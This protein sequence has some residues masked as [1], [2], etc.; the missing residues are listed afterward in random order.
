MVAYV[1]GPREII[2]RQILF[3]FL[4]INM[5]RYNIEDKH[6]ELFEPQSIFSRTT[7]SSDYGLNI[8]EIFL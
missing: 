4:K 3:I 6:G 2:F 7:P 8:F 5:L 1:G